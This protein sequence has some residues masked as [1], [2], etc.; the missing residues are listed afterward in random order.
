MSAPTSAYHRK[1]QPELVRRAILDHAQQLVLR[2]GV[3]NVTIQAVA[4]AAG[5][6]KGG[7]FHHFANKQAL[8][9]AMF[10]DMVDKLDAAIT[11]HIAEDGGPGCFTRAYV[12]VLLVNDTFGVGSPFDALGVAAGTD[13]AMGQLWLD[14]VSNRLALHADTDSGPDLQIIRFA[15][16]GAWLSYF[17][18]RPDVDLEALRDRL[19]AMARL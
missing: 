16:D 12:D 15:C 2:D 13:A 6:T 18:R 5:V 4:D 9:S 8:L 17:G 1:K 19:L 3:G 11:A 14:W 7:V 10:V